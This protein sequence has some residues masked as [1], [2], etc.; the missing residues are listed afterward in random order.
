MLYNKDMIDMLTVG[1][2]LGAM[3]GA[4]F[5]SFAV[6]QVW[7]LRA[8]QLVADKKAGEE[9]DVE[10][11][12]RL[13]SLVGK[14]VKEDRSRCL[15]C[16]H[17][18]SWADLLPVL[19]WVHLRGKCRYCKKPI[20]WTEIIAELS[21]G[22]LFALSI[23]FWPGALTEPLECV[24][25]ILWL[26]AL[27]VLTINF[28]YDARWFLLVSGLNWLLIGLGA[29]F[30]FITLM[31]SPDSVGALW[32]LGGA[33]GIL[34]GLY[35]MLWVVSR[36]AWVGEGDIYLGVGLALFLGDWRLAF[37]ALFSAN[38]IGT[39]IVLPS[40]VSG[41]LKRGSHLPFGPLLIAGSL[42]AWF[43]GPMIVSW[44]Q[45]LVLFP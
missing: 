39:L 40:L 41:K 10:E 7:R 32:S 43:L 11:L 29:A 35:A 27:V 8:E 19:S 21:L 6:A 42:V 14:K 9:Y 44:Y 28:I 45:Q 12:H 34:G 25:L 24:K 5:G 36:G 18:L 31:Q 23:L 38:L 3:L 37:V 17:V 22:G 13:Q 1:A 33:V 20:G 2:L 16:G 26:A 15:S 30:A 4:I